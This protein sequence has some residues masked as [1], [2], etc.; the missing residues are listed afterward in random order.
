MTKGWIVL[1]VMAVCVTHCRAQVKVV[2]APDIVEAITRVVKA[3]DF[4]KAVQILGE[5][6]FMPRY[7]G[8][9]S[10]KLLFDIDAGMMHGYAYLC[11]A[12]EDRK[13]VGMILIGSNYN[14]MGVIER[15]GE[16]GVELS[17]GNRPDLIRCQWGEWYGTL[18]VWKSRREYEIEFRQRPFQH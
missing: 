15:L 17:R 11:P 5:Y 14:L 4:Q 3:E 12:L 13:K 10:G 2:V 16:F 9:R 8:K 7:V 6:G 18:E 1:M